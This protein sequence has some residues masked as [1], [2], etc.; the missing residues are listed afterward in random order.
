M[1]LWPHSASKPK[2]RYHAGHGSTEAF[3]AARMLTDHAK[4]RVVI[5]E[6]GLPRPE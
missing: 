4:D 5:R 6:V 3:V 2:T 1:A